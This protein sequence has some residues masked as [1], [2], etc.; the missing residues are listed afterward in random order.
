ILG[1]SICTVLKKDL[2]SLCSLRLIRG[3][4]ES[5]SRDLHPNRLGLICHKKAA[6][7]SEPAFKP[8]KVKKVSETYRDR[9]EER[10]LGKEGDY[11]QVEAILEEFEKRNT[12]NEDREVVIWSHVEETFALRYHQ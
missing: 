9:A 7:S 2:S 12:D 1:C 6:F 5:V 10:R 4:I 3:T 11:A 8:R